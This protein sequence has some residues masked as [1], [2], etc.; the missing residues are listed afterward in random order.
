MPHLQFD[1]NL[2][3]SEQ[4]KKDFINHVVLSFSKIMQTGLDH[5]AVSF[6]ETSKNS[7]FLGRSVDKDIILMNLDIRAGRK[8]SQKRDLALNYMNAAQKILG[9]DFK[10]QYLT[11]TSHNGEDFNLHEKSLSGWTKNDKPI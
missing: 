8:S 7:V 1:T 4:K 3:I 10:N 11:F 5:I 6:R 2:K 9:I